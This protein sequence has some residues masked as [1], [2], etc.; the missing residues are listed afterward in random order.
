MQ[1]TN[2]RRYFGYRC[3]QRDAEGT[4]FFFVFCA[5][6]K[7]LNKWI[8]IKRT[9]ETSEGHQRMLRPPR[10]KAIKY[11][12]SSEPV[13]TIPNNILIAFDKGKTTFFPAEDR[14]SSC[15]SKSEMDNN[16]G[17]KIDWG[18]LE[19]EFDESKSIEEF[20]K[21]AFIVDGQHRLLG[22]VSFDSEE[23][24]LLTVCLLDA[25]SQEQAFQFIVIN[26]KAVKVQ[27]DNVKAIIANINEEILEKRLEKA[28]VKY[29]DSTPMLK[30]ISDI[31]TSPFFNLLTWDYNQSDRTDNILVPVTAIEQSLKFIVTIF[32]FFGEDDD[33]L[34]DFFINV[35]NAIKNKYPELWNVNK[36]FMRKVNINALNEYAIENLSALWNNGFVE[37]IFDKN[38]IEEKINRI[39]SQIPT[40]FWTTQW[41]VKIQD[42]SNVRSLIKQD[43]DKIKENV[44]LKKNWKDKLELLSSA[45]LDSSEKIS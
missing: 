1:A 40:D 22:S 27:T 41:T 28:G 33:T 19:F 38:E 42:N 45:N 4:V 14:I 31:D 39:F 37:N 18:F 17:S 15:I 43:L 10:T 26:N 24:P 8:G 11:F 21:P 25:D 5:N 16:C 6:A 3:K 30:L 29:G 34:L 36:D 9:R 35:W 44:R 32:E 7:D 12:L 2:K 13:N 23:L 20:D